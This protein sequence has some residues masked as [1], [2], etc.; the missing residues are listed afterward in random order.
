MAAWPVDDRGMPEK[1]ASVARVEVVLRSGD[2]GDDVW[3]HTRWLAI[4]EVIQAG[5]GSW[6]VVAEESPT[7]IGVQARYIC[8]PA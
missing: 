7:H 1:A 8:S 2:A 6:R 3:L 5:A 4:G